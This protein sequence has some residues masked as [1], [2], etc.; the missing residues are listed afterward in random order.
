[1]CPS[2]SV[3]HATQKATSLAMNGTKTNAPL[4]NAKVSISASGKLK[5]SSIFAHFSFRQRNGPTGQLR[6]TGMQHYHVPCWQNKE[7]EAGH[8]EQ[9][10]S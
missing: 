4:A 8:R 6:E 2:G 1:V 7:G 5:C 3:S 10:L 9:L